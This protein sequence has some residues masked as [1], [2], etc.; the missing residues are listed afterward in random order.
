MLNLM[1]IKFKAL[2]MLTVFAANFCA[3]CHCRH[4]AMMD[5]MYDASNQS[6]MHQGK[7]DCTDRHC[8]DTN[9]ASTKTPSNGKGDCSRT[10]AIKFSLLEKQT[11]QKIN[12]H[13]LSF[14]SLTDNFIYPIDL[15]LPSIK[16]GDDILKEWL[17][18]Q[19]PPNF[20][21]LFQSFL[22]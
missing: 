2:F 22:I 20:Q 4:L 18:K 14:T 7:A 17:N 8:T 3:V 6:K 11:A 1:P 19:S 13:P 9:C 15:P 21:A 16:K 10:Q 12:L 5:V